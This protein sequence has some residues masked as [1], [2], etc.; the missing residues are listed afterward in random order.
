MSITPHVRVAC[1]RGQITNTYLP[2]LFLHVHPLHD[3]QPWRP[4]V[5][6][7]VC[8]AYIINSNTALGAIPEPFKRQHSLWA[9]NWVTITTGGASASRAPRKS[10]RFEIP[11]RSIP[12][13]HP[14]IQDL[15]SLSTTYTWARVVP[16]YLNERPRRQHS[17]NIIYI[18]TGCELRSAHCDNVLSSLSVVIS[19]GGKL[20]YSYYLFHAPGT[21]LLSTP[22]LDPFISTYGIHIHKM[23]TPPLFII[24]SSFLLLLP[25]RLNCPAPHIKAA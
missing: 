17:G 20:L 4:S 12:W 23:T 9:T 13:P 25:V 22:G 11:D 1:P 15:G 5:Q 16:K 14:W 7:G 8:L 6:P 19:S 3:D 24:L 2:L 10:S 18:I 21:R